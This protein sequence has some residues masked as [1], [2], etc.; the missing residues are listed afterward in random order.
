[1]S[2]NL[3][4]TQDA[5]DEWYENK[6]SM[7]SIYVKWIPNELTE[8]IAKDYFTQCLGTVSRVEFAKH[9]SGKG[10]ILFVHFTSWTGSEESVNIRKSIISSHADGF[11]LEI[12]F[13]TGDINT[14][15]SYYL[16]CCINIRPIQIIEYNTHQLYDMIQTLNKEISNLKLEISNLKCKIDNVRNY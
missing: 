9:K 4:L 2:E 5:I 15:K 1:M 6:N 16:K 14:F 3:T 13:Q 8:H 10:R 11:A 12:K 7:S